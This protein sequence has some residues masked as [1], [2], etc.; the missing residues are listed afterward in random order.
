VL[1]VA[2]QLQESHRATLDVA[3]AHNDVALSAVLIERLRGEEVRITLPSYY[4]NKD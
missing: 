2:L 1:S 4:L 3:A